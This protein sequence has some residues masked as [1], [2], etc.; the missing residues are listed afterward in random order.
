[1]SHRRPKAPS[2][3]V[4]LGLAVLAP[5]S[6]PAAA[7]A[8][9]P[10]ASEGQGAAQGSSQDV[11][12]VRDV[13]VD[14]TA[15]SAAAAR[16]QAITEAQ[17]KAFQQLVQ[18][19]TPPGTSAPSASDTQVASLVQDFEVQRERSSSVRY[20]ATL[21]VRF[22]PNAVRSLLQ[23]SGV[24]FAEA[25][26]KPMLVLPVYRPGGG[27]PL[28]WEDR[29]PWRSAWENTSPNTGLVPF[30]VPYGELADIADVSAEEALAGDADGFSAIAERYGADD[31][32]VVEMDAPADGP[33]PAT[34]GRVTVTRHTAA[35]SQP[36]QVVTIPAAPDKPVEEYLAGGVA[37]VNALLERQW[38]EET[39][40]DRRNE[41]RMDVTV[42]VARLDDWIR[43]RRQITQVPA[44][45]RADLRRLS[46]QEAEVELV[47]YGDPERLRAALARQ[48]LHLER[49]APTVPPMQPMA[50]ALP[51]APVPPGM[52]ALPVQQPVVEQWRLYPSGSALR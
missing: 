40:V 11:Y 21:T 30:V 31:V 24:A 44:V 36:S 5:L 43:T 20:L 4:A 18:R 22:R 27:Q 48:D 42:P 51:G 17:R 38:K 29:T 39:A 16:D 46:R 25:R 41:Q 32:V 1:M 47:Y 50:G 13:E 10:A 8:Q 34:E 26:S 49:A 23:G 12:T 15:A 37:A 45:A 28:L 52:P 2:L 33:D 6:L 9:A 14:V 3:A 19:L 35:G 7:R